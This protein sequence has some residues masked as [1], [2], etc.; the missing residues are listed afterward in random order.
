MQHLNDAACQL[1]AVLARLLR[2]IE[3]GPI[4]DGGRV[5]TVGWRVRAESRQRH[6]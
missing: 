3:I 1:L 2:D 4:I 5:S 6:G